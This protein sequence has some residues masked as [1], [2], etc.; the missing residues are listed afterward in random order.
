[1]SRVVHCG[2]I[3]LIICPP[4]LD[5]KFVDELSR[6][7]DKIFARRQRFAC[8]TDTSLLTSMPDAVN[9]KHLANWISRP[10]IQAVQTELNVGSSTI[11][12]STAM[13]A[14]M[15]ALYWLW[16]PPTPQHAAKDLDEALTWSVSKLV[17]ADPRL[18]PNEAILKAQVRMAAPHRSPNKAAS[19][20]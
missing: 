18:V 9:R 10:D 19:A 5:E 11:L 12:E 15:T 7:F 8:I 17:A 4:K 1:M 13:R 20:G 6:E 2:S 16:T 14:V 3:V